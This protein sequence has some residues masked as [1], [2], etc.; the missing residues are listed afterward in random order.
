[1]QET[2]GS[3][4]CRCRAFPT[5]V[6]TFWHWFFD[7]WSFLTAA[8]LLWTASVLTSLRMG[9]LTTLGV[10]PTDDEAVQLHDWCL[11]NVGVVGGH[12]TLFGQIYKAQDKPFFN[13]SSSIYL[14][15][16]L[17]GTA[18]STIQRVNH[19]DKVT[20]F[21]TNYSSCMFKPKRA[22]QHDRRDRAI[23]SWCWW[24]IHCFI[25]FTSQQSIC[26]L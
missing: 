15:F 4:A 10:P 18:N 17:K 12:I 21:Q 5:S 13:Y 19:N 11:P 9:V 16:L 14:S 25:A 7:H 6:W 22:Y 23:I 3:C 26:Y 1:M 2:D 24:N 20:G 8:H